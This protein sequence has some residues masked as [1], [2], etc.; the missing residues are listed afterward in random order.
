MAQW[1]LGRFPNRLQPCEM[2]DRIGCKAGQRAGQRILIAQIALDLGHVAV[3][4][5]AHTRERDRRTARKIVEDAN[6][7]VRRE[8]C[9]QR[10]AADIARPAGAEDFRPIFL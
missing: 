10:V 3:G 6:V 4:Q 2:D 1:L 8:Q 7:V 9:N 5:P